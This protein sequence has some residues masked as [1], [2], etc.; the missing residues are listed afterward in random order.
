MDKLQSLLSKL[1]EIF[2]YLL[3]SLASVVLAIPDVLQ[4]SNWWILIVWLVF[5]SLAILMEYRTKLSRFDLE[6]SLNTANSTLEKAQ[7]T[8]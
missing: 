8:S 3:I 6:T 7:Y 5:W 1:R 4:G 2:P